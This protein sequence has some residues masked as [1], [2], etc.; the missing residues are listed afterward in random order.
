MMRD[1]IQIGIIGGGAMSEALIAGLTTR[2]SV[3]ASHISV[4]EHKAVRCDAL[5]QRYGIH[6]QVG[7]ESFLPRIDV[8]ILAVKPAA[9]A[10]AMQETAHL[11]K[12]GALVLSIVAGLT[13]AEIEAAYP[14]HPVVRAMPNTPLAVGAGMSAYACGTHAGAAEL[15]AA[16]MILGAAGRTVAVHEG[17]LDAVTGLS[18]SGPA[19]AFL[20]MEALIEGG[21]A[22]GLKRET[23]A[24]LAAQTLMGAA[25]MALASAHSPADLRAAVTSPA[26]TTAAGLRVMERAGV[27]SALIEAVLAAAERSK[28]LG[29]K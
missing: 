18:G 5:T 24:L 23:A 28:E 11:L 6:A 8:F 22:A 3:P 9:A 2:G 27:R 16:E 21:V 12:E 29:R 26:G 20:M 13:I 17:D 1:D 15:A 7:A 25:Q 10:A 14:A 19:Y 4:S